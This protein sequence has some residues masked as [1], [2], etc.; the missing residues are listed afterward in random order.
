HIAHVSA[1]GSVRL[2]R[3]AKAR[4][5]MVTAETAPHYFTLTEEAL[6]NFSTNCKMHPPLRS[7]E[8][9]RA[10]KEG[11]G[12]GTI[13][14]IASDHAPHSSIEKDLEFDYA[15]NGIIGLETS[16]ALSLE[17]VAEGVLSLASLIEKMTVNPARIL[18]LPKGTLSSGA[19]ADITIID[20]NRSWIADVETFRSKSRNSPFQGRPMH[21]KAVM[22]I[23]GGI[24]KYSDA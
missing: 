13:D 23:V 21:G 17:L 8:D 19:D 14:A 11:L 24:V 18:K 3:E 7:A 5:V 4:G 2:I 16:L 15:A 10:L 12:D 1:A 6:R 22:T 20:S 9:V